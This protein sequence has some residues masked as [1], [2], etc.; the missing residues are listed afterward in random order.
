MMYMLANDGKSPALDAKYLKFSCLSFRQSI[1][2]RLNVAIKT[3]SQG[4]VHTY[5][6]M[7]VAASLN[8]LCPIKSKVNGMCCINSLCE[9]T[10]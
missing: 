9:Q 6:Q 1:R 10:I 7:S 3:N 2:Y 8:I 5:L 4:F